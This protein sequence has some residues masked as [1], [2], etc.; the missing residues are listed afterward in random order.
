[1]KREELY[2]TKYRSENELKN[3]IDDY[4]IFYN[5]QRPQSKIRYKTPKQFEAEYTSKHSDLENK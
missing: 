4:M 2:R 5:K 1:M 3:G